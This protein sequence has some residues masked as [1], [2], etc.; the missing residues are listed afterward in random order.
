MGEQIPPDANLLFVRG[1]DPVSRT[2]LYDVN[3]RF[4]S[5]RPSE[6]ATHALPFV[7]LQ[8]SIDVG[9]PRERQLLTQR[10]DLGRTREGDRATPESMKNFATSVIPNPMAMVL[11]QQ[12]EL[13]LSRAQ[14]D[15][16]ATLSFEFSVFTDSVWTP[17]TSYFVGLPDVY[18]AGEAY[19]RYVTARER[20]IDYLMTLVPEASGVLTGGQRRRLPWQIG[21]YLD[22]RVL[23][24][25]RWSLAP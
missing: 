19:A 15:S 4:G 17:V 18:S 1:F 11:T 22:L 20:T 25:L 8:V 14:A 3:Q 23:R 6:S 13:K 9:V 21:N 7:S 24:Y 2:Y 10:L 16:L 12:A 5:T